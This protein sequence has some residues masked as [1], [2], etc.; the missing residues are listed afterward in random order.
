MA[1]AALRLAALVAGS[2]EPAPTDPTC[3]RAEYFVLEEVEAGTDV[4][5]SA[6][7][8][9][10]EPAPLRELG[11][12]VLRQSRD[13]ERLLLEWEL[14]FA[15]PE[16]P[17]T[18]VHHVELREQGLARCVWRE[19]RPGSGRTLFLEELDSGVLRSVEWGG[20]AGLREEFVP[21]PGSRF[22][23]EL[24]EALRD[25][26]AP[27]G[28]LSLYEPL[29]GRHGPVVLA[30]APLGLAS[31]AAFASVDLRAPARTFALRRPDGT[32]ALALRFEGA[33]LT[34]FQ[35]QAGNAR[36]R[37]IS[38]EA[39]RRMLSELRAKDRSADAP[40]ADSQPSPID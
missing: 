19:Y 13:G 37:R 3:V 29:T 4:L 35:W 18:R 11:L 7:V 21:L 34:A 8:P 24:I 32:L 2:P 16:G 25:G 1:A 26:R 33:E 6:P 38:A 10:R 20:E 17:D 40:S 39:W 22:P 9:G 27:T 30:P 14:H 15:D 12:A 23:L 36:A 5:A 28:P 31:P